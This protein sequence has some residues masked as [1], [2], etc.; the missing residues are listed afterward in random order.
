MDG[1]GAGAVAGAWVTTG[2]AVVGAGAAGALEAD[3][4][5]A[6]DGLVL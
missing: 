2:E 6:A 4:D 1:A 5:D 3:A